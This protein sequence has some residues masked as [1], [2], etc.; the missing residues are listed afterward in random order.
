VSDPLLERR[1]RMA[2]LAEVGQRVGYAAIL[3]A[4]VAFAWALIADFPAGATTT[5]V[6]AMA[7]A[8]VTLAPAIVLGYAVKAAEKEDRERGL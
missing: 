6:V 7:L 8:T 5:V 1:A 3:V 2:K 4:V